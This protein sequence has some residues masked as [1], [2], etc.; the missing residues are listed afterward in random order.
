MSNLVNYIQPVKF[1]SFEAAKSKLVDFKLLIAELLWSILHHVLQYY[2]QA[3][4][5]LYNVN[6]LEAKSYMH[7]YDTL[8]YRVQ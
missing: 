6:V 3:H 5:I 4:N 7:I 1:T 2:M 8:F